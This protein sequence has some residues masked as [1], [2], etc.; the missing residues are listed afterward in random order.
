[1]F[2]EKTASKLLQW[3]AWINNSGVLLLKKQVDSRLLSNYWSWG[4][5][6]DKVLAWGKLNRVFI[7]SKR[8]TEWAE[9]LD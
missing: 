2:I 7:I 9:V 6:W 5:E 8:V 4:V 1:M 3:C